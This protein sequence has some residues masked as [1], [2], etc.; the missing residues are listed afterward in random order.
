MTYNQLY[1]LIQELVFGQDNR[2]YILLN[3]Y[4]ERKFIGRHLPS[5][6]EQLNITIENGSIESWDLCVEGV[7]KYMYFAIPNNFNTLVSSLT[8]SSTVIDLRG[9]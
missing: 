2:I 8:S 5:L 3:E 1:P 6:F 9:N 7:K 4:D